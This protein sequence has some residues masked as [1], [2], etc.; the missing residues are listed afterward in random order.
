MSNE[1]IHA[2]QALCANA[3]G[4]GAITFFV[5]SAAGPLVAMAGGVPVAMLLGNGAGIPAMFLVAAVILLPFAAGFT[6]MSQHVKNA[7]GFYA[8]AAR[9]LGGHAAGTTAAIAIFSYTAIQVG[10]YGLFGASAATLLD[11]QLH[12][13]LPW[14]LFSFAA[15]AGIGLLGFRQV[16]LSAKILSVLVIGEY[17]VVLIL[18]YAVL[19]QAGPNIS[20]AS[21]TPAVVSSGSPWIGLLMCFSA[22]IGFEATTI[23]AEEARK[24]EQT[25]PIATYVSLLLIGSFYVFSSWCMVVGVGY[26]RVIPILSALADPTTFLFQLT[27][28]YV[29]AWLSFIMRLLF[30]TSIFAALLAFHNSIARYLFALGRDLLL[31]HT[32][33]RTHPA[34]RSPYIASSIQSLSAFLLVLAFVLAGADPVVVLFARVSALGTLGVIALMVIASA[35]VFMFFR[36]RLGGN[37]WRVRLFPPLSMVCLGAVLVLGC[38]HFDALAGESSPLVRWLPILLLAAAL[39]GL[40]MADR[41]RRRDNADLHQESTPRIR[42][43]TP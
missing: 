34:R 25:I 35:S 29:G 2:S 22:F 37:F 21:F 38:I 41:L 17:F 36:H 10:L 14:W 4:V 18:D 15:I 31:P 3:L 40:A 9:G 27:D 43:G 32:L 42:S 23:Y 24:P 33:A 13:Q 6:A 5:I 39:L 28:Q 8:F 16:D 26:K 11:Q 30:L 20:A 12:L 7:G 19:A 1:E